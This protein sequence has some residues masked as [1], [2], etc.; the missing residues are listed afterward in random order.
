MAGCL[1]V[2][3][4]I[5]RQPPYSFFLNSGIDETYKAVG[6]FLSPIRRF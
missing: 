4:Q 6:I 1:V 5:S 2:Q 3:N